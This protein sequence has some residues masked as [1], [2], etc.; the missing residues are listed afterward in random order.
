MSRDWRRHKPVQS[1]LA[2]SRFRGFDAR[3]RA[4]I[5]LPMGGLNTKPTDSNCASLGLPICRDKG[6]QTRIERL[7][8]DIAG[9]STQID[10]ETPTSAIHVRGFCSMRLGTVHRGSSA[11]TP[12]ASSMRR[13]LA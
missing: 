4:D 7:F 5:A 8:L 13:A 3:Q 1:K 12:K 9:H 6:N 11:M 2:I 10:D